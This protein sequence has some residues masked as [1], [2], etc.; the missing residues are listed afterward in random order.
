MENSTFL[1][2]AI[3]EQ[4]C[5]FGAYFMFF[6]LIF[7]STNNAQPYTCLILDQE[8][9]ELVFLQTRKLLRDI[10]LDKA[11]LRDR[12]TIDQNDTEK[13]K[14]FSNI[15]SLPQVGTGKSEPFLLTTSD[16]KNEKPIDTK[17]FK[18]QNLVNKKD[19][20]ELQ[21]QQSINT[22]SD[23]KKKAKSHNIKNIDQKMRY[24]SMSKTEKKLNISLESATPYKDMGK[25]NSKGA[26]WT[27]D[28]GKINETEDSDQ[29][30]RDSYSD[31]RNGLTSGSIRVGT[32]RQAKAF[33]KTYKQRLEAVGDAQF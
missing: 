18:S 7:D 21:D 20:I 32:K 28:Y 5:L 17:T 26:L 2:I 27:P 12:T 6:L 8:V 15:K 10:H 29:D 19:E 14:S 11:V 4:V 31:N 22:F 24:N 30:G 13:F 33:L 3:T 23:I 25:S 1:V 9:P 16:Q